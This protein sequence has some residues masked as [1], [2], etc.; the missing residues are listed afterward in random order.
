MANKLKKLTIR[1]GWYWSAGKKF[2]WSDNYAVPGVGIAR[3]WF[4]EDDFLVGIG[5]STYKVNSQEAID[6]IRK[7]KSHERK[8]KIN[9]GYISQ[10]LMHK[11]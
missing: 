8:G 7:H 4:D 5:E 1:N 9:I 3:S 2:G 6:F 10:D 11:V